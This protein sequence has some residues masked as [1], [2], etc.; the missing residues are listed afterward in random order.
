MVR[1]KGVARVTTIGEKDLSY[2]FVV[3]TASA[4]KARNV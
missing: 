2:T 3:R 1:G 4:Y